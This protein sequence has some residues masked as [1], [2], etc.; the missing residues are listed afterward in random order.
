MKPRQLLSTRRSRHLAAGGALVLGIA[1]LG[2]TTFL[3]P[4]GAQDAAVA[5]PIAATDARVAPFAP[6]LMTAEPRTV[7][8]DVVPVQ[9]T[10]QDAEPRKVL[11]DL[12]QAQAPAP[13]DAAPARPAPGIEALAQ[14]IGGYAS[15]DGAF[16]GEILDS[17]ELPNPIVTAMAVADR[18]ALIFPTQNGRFLV[19]GLVFDLSTGKTIRTI[20]ELRE[21]S[22]SFD[23]S[24]LD[25][26]PKDV[27]PMYYGTGPERVMLFVDPYCPWCAAL[28][29][30]LKDDPSLAEAYTFEIYAV[31]YLGDRSARA[32]TAVSC[33]PREEGLARLL[34]KDHQWMETWNPP[35]DGSCDPVPIMQRTIFAQMLGVSGVPF[36]VGPSGRTSKGMP[37]D[38]LRAF[39]LDG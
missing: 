29:D 17:M 4:A 15:T 24:A 19:A 28:F 38:G 16:P 39:L 6:H 20:E 30:Q 18:D 13:Q 7:Q 21:A 25:I 26:D 35:S 9:A 27:D 22:A 14:T 31:P 11:E 10:R 32:V 1:A 8:Q 37:Q 3:T 34:A 12:V 36:I 5:A 2:T 33:A 23:P